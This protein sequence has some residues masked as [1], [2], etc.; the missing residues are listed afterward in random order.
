[1]ASAAVDLNPDSTKEVIPL[2]D[3][4]KFQSEKSIQTAKKL[5]DAFQNS[6]FVYLKNHGVSQNVVDE[7]FAWVGLLLSSKGLNMKCD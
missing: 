1:M 7:A 2:I 5:F 6:G 4:S 3:F